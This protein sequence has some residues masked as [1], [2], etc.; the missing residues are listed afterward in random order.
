MSATVN[1]SQI[2]RSDTQ[3]KI[4]WDIGKAKDVIIG[5]SGDGYSLSPK[6]FECKH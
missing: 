6:L 4:L 3:V 2:L 1:K 5:I